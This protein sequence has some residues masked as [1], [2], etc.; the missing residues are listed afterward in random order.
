M[1]RNSADASA[2]VMPEMITLKNIVIY[3]LCICS[4][5]VAK[6]NCPL[7]IVDMDNKMYFIYLL[8]FVIAES[9]IDGRRGG[10]PR[11]AEGPQDRVVSD[12]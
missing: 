7:T 9:A 12:L 2:F 4:I 6:E 10:S 11:Q 1:C 3:I 5:C 8:L